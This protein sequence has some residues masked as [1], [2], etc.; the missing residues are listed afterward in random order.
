MNVPYTSWLQLEN[1]Y[2]NEM[3]WMVKITL[4]IFM[5]MAL[6]LFPISKFIMKKKHYLI[7]YLNYIAIKPLPVI[8]G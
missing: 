5:N 3:V 6:V 4:S 2:K 7:K 8:K 1:G